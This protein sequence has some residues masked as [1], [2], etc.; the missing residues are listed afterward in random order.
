MHALAPNVNAPQICTTIKAS[1]SPRWFVMSVTTPS[2]PEAEPGADRFRSLIK[3]LLAGGIAALLM[4][5]FVSVGSEV[6]EGDT[7]AFDTSVLHGAQALRAAHPWIAE[8][9]RDL[10]GVG[11]TVAL[12]LF[13]TVTVLYLAL[14]SLRRLALLVAVSVVSGSILVSLFKVAFGRL[15]PDTAF[16][17][18]VVSGLSFPSGHA[19]MSAIVFLTVGSLVASTRGRWAERSFILAVAALMTLLVGASRVALGV[20]WATDVVGGWAFGSAWALA[21]LLLARRLARR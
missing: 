3:P 16:A 8:V 19:S 4:L 5:G 10:S 9:M 17:E 12:A 18:L 2:P 6:L 1:R 20:H 21:W 11:S 7:R 15:R 14:F 13:T